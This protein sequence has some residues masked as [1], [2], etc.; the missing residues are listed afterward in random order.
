[1]RRNQLNAHPFTAVQAAS[2]GKQISVV[3]VDSGY[4]A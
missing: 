1:M 2:R 3:V 4:F